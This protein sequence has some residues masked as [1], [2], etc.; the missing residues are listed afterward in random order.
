MVRTKIVHTSETFFEHFRRN[1]QKYIKTMF[2]YRVKYTESEYD[3]QNNDLLYKIDQTCQD[4]FDILENFVIIPKNK[5]LN[6]LY[7]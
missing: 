1:V 4:T 6:F 3:I 2:P 5:I 7:V